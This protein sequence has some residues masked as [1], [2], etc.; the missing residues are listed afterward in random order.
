MVQ[1]SQH[2]PTALKHTRQNVAT[3]FMKTVFEKEFSDNYISD[4]LTEA[5]LLPADSNLRLIA[6]HPPVKLLWKVCYIDLMFSF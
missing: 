4:L 2:I 1:L 6:G 3:L 5:D